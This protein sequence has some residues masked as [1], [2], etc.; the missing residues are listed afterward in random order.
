[1][2]IEDHRTNHLIEVNDDKL[3]P[4]FEQ[5]HFQSRLEIARD[6]QNIQSG[7][8]LTILHSPRC[9]KRLSVEGVATTLRKLSHVLTQM[10]RV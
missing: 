7:V 2:N 4:E 8:L 1:M 5:I 3:S 10:L 9:P 6:Q